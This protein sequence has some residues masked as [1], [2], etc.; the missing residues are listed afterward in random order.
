MFAEFYQAAQLAPVFAEH[1]GVKV[2]AFFVAG[3]RLDSLAECGRAVWLDRLS[4]YFIG[5]FNFSLDPFGSGPRL[6]FGGAA[7]LLAT[8]RPAEMLPAITPLVKLIPGVRAIERV[9]D[10]DRD[11]RCAHSFILRPGT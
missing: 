9:S 1:G 2:L 6:F 10:K 11:D 3:E 7:V 8:V 4:H 5:Q